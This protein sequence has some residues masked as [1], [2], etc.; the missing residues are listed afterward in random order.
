MA[1][2]KSTAQSRWATWKRRLKWL[3]AAAGAIALA[4]ALV[5]L[6]RPGGNDSNSDL[7]YQVY[8]ATNIAGEDRDK[9]AAE[10]QSFLSENFPPDEYEYLGIIAQRQP[11]AQSPSTTTYVLFKRK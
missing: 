2:G 3:A 6:F 4:A 1:D 9:T 8:V 10:I 5:W 11:T 7:S